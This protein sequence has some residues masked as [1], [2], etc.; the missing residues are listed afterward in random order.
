M[1]DKLFHAH[2]AI[3]IDNREHLSWSA[4]VAHPYPTIPL[5]S[6]RCICRPAPATGASMHT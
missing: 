2:A 5:R 3:S 1:A 6:I 4:A